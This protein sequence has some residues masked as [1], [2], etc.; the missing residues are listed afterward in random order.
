MATTHQTA[1][2]RRS[3]II[4]TGLNLGFA[5]T[6]L[7]TGLWANSLV[8]IAGALHDAGDAV[9]LMLSYLGLRLSLLPPN[10]QRTF[11]YRKI[12]VL[13][14]FVNALALTVLT[15]LVIRTAFTRIFNPETVKSPVMIAMAILGIFVNGTAV[16]I[17]N[18]HRHSLNIRAAMWH[19]LDDLL[20]SGAVLV[21]G[22]IIGITNW[23]VID[24]LLSI[25]IALLVIYGT[26]RIFRQSVNILIDATPQDL[27]Y[28]TVRNFILGFSPEIR[29]IHDLHIWTLGE[30]ER[31]LSAHLVVND[32]MLSSFQPLLSELT[33]SL[34]K[35]FAITHITLELECDRCKS[36][37]NI[38]FE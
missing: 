29:A 10:G 20:G 9:A 24:P 6:E 35:R 5:L 23:T 13:I 25:A 1:L 30:K 14:A 37:D 4:S 11:G 8:L 36:K 12:Q 31:A 19:L 34:E 7:L 17:L 32:G 27:N 3:L 38:C 28:D 22:I 16:L 21:S 15:V 2:Q 26:Y 18:R 33:C